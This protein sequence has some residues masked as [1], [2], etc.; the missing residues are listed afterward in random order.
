MGI[1]LFSSMIYTKKMD[2]NLTFYIKNK[3]IKNKNSHRFLGMIFDSKLTWNAHI[4]DLKL[5][6]EKILP[7][8]SYLDVIEDYFYSSIKLL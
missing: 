7:V 1:D 2:K 8:L 6:C 4:K 5:R 3:N